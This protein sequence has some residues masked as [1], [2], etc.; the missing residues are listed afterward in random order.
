MAAW[1]TSDDLEDALTEAG[2][3]VPGAGRLSSAL[4][5]AIEAF[6]AA[7]GYTPF[8]AA[9]EAEP[10][11]DTLYWPEDGSASVISLGGAVLSGES[12]TVTLD[13]T[14][15]TAGTDYELRPTNA[16]RTGRPYT[17][18]VLTNRRLSRRSPEGG[19]Q[20]G[21]LTLTGIWGWCASDAVPELARQAVLA[22]A[23]LDIA[24]PQIQSGD[25]T[26]GKRKIDQ[27]TVTIEYGTSTEERLAAVRAWEGDWERAVA[28]FRRKSVM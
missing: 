28:H 13:T 23:L 2:I 4:A 21:K 5:L 15:L 25:A 22:Y 24:A 27:G 3:P 9:S 14:E 8:A 26:Q 1:P 16:T 20:A 6:E 11:T 18:L 7:T 10:A 19:I 17:Y 12:V